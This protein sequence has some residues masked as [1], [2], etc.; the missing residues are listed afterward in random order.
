MD[1]RGQ[2]PASEV[3]LAPLVIAI[4]RLIPAQTLAGRPKRV[5]MPG[6]D[7]ARST[8]HQGCD[9]VEMQALLP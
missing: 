8:E 6:R 9:G 5:L 4:I 2:A 1:E 7:A 3:I